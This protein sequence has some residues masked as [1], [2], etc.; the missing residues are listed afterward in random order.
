MIMTKEQI[1]EFQ[2]LS[3]PLIKWIN[4]NA[5]PFTQIEISCS[6]AK[7][8]SGVCSTVTNEYIPD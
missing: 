3:N 5:D 6:S 2:T 4:E 1:K 8:L 7:V